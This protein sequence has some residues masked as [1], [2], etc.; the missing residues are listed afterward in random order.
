[1]GPLNVFLEPLEL[2][3]S[4]LVTLHLPEMPTPTILVCRRLVTSIPG[5]RPGTKQKVPMKIP[6][7]A[8][9]TAAQMETI[10]GGVQRAP[11]RRGG[12]LI[13]L[14]LLLLLLGRRRE[15][16]GGIGQTF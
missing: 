14:L 4:A 1:M 7:L 9:L 13:V 3:C 16:G 8:E 11:V 15:T 5:A 10:S 2:P 12:G 6:G